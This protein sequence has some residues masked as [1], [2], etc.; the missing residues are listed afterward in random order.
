MRWSQ[1]PR[2]DALDMYPDYSDPRADIPGYQTLIDTD[3]VPGTDADV[4]EFL[5]SLFPR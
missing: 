2:D 1:H 5:D 4:K 3:D